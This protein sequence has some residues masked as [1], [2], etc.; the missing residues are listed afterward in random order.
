MA[1]PFGRRTP[2]LSVIFYRRATGSEPV[3]EWP[4]SLA[5]DDRKAIGA[6]IKAVQYSW[7]I[8]MPLIRRLEPELWEVR[9]RLQHVIARV[10]ITI[11]GS[12]MVLLHGFIKKSQQTPNFEL[13]LARAR[14]ADLHKR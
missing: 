8:G 14:L 7:P 1:D 2:I 6:D 5:V 10:V 12:A 9:S 13:R 11:D 3:R 4:K